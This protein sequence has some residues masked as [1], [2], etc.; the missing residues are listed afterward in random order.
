M[1]LPARETLT[2]ADRW[3][4]TRLHETIVAVDAFL[5][6]YDFGNV[7][8]TVWRFIWY[9]FCDWYVEA[10]KAS[11]NRATRAGVLSFVWNNAMR[12]LHPIAPFI[13]EEVWLALPHDGPTIVTAAWPDAQEVPTFDRDARDFERLQR[14]VERVRNVRAAIG[15]HPRARVEIDVPEDVP[16]ELCDLLALQTAA[17]VERSA[18]V[19]KTLDEAL[20]AVSVRAPRGILE[21]R[22][23]KDLKTLQMEIDRGERKL[24][25]ES[26]VAK[27]PANVVAKE[28]EKLDGY[29]AE[30]ARVEAALH[31][32]KEPA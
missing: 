4:L 28:R 9:E 18:A 12:V 30:L 26:F 7:A 16:E 32:L 15:L 13:S 22:Y 3:I 5:A 1:V 24:G 17:T 27:A 23:R 10:T 2:H 11:A 25:N 19:G 14:T 6:R 29:R 31:A 21:E 8:E 20:A